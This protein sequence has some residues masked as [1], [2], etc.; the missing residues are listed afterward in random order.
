MTWKPRGY[1]ACLIS[2]F[3]DKSNISATKEMIYTS[4]QLGL[5]ELGTDITFTSN[6]KATPP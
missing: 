6:A 3:S 4:P 5:L 2:D 1:T